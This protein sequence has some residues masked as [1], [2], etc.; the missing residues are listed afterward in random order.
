MKFVSGNVL[1]SVADAAS[2]MTKDLD[3]W[4]K[5]YFGVT[6]EPRVNSNHYGKG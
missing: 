3:T 5:I 4:M 2:P 1:E 6:G